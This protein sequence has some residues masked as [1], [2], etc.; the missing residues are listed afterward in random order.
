M[1]YIRW[2]SNL[3]L[4]DS[5]F[6]NQRLSP[7]GDAESQR[8]KLNYYIIILNMLK[9]KSLSRQSRE[10]VFWQ[11]LIVSCKLTVTKWKSIQPKIKVGY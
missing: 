2:D 6:S 4:K 1:Q 5:M 9:E 3:Y 10:K 8:N 11:L 7:L